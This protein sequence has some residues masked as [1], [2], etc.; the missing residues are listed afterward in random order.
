VIVLSLRC[1]GVKFIADAM[2]LV[3]PIR[4]TKKMIGSGYLNLEKI[5]TSVFIEPMS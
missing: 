2:G 5:P 4:L 3:P 1:A